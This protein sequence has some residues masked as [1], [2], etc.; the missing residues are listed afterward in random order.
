MLFQ[1]TLK[2]PGGNDNKLKIES[3]GL[4][5]KEIPLNYAV[6]IQKVLLNSQH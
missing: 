3:Q 5:N 6:V 2:L 1:N 4:D